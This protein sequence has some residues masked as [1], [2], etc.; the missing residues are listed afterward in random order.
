M[1]TI[2]DLDTHPEP[3]VSV[4][5]LAAYWGVNRRTITRDIEK[6]ALMAYKVGTTEVTRIK[7]ADARAHGRP[8]GSNRSDSSTA[9]DGTKSDAA[10]S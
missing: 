7:I 9:T 8:V 6:G 5:E 4:D 10:R 3:T 1:G 2:F